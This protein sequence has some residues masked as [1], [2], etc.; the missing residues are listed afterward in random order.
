MLCLHI[1]EHHGVQLRQALLPQQLAG[2]A[3]AVGT[4]IEFQPAQ[5]ACRQKWKPAVALSE[6][7]CW[8]P[9]QQRWWSSF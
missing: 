1:L 9:K 4:E 3:A 6:C 7:A 8:A 2:K 5:A